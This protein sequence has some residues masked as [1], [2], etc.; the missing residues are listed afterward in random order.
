MS[1][2]GCKGELEKILDRYQYKK[3]SLLPCLHAVCE[4]CGY[5]SEE[6]ISFLA[7][8]L[9]LPR[10]KVYSVAS[11]YSLFTFEKTGKYIIRICVSLPCYLKGSKEI[12]GV[13][14]EELGI[15]AGQTT[16][17]KKFSLETVSCLG[18]CDKAPAMMIN[19]KLY[20]NLTPEKVRKIIQDY[21]K[22]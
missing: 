1:L 12:L 6:I 15:E 14:K 20:G 3:E 17:D 18:A 9:N 10:V 11:F 5:L 8:E 2:K 16:S 7:K 4:R 22:K 19:E 13:L 21:K